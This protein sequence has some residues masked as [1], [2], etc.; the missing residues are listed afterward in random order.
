[1][2][3]PIVEQ[4]T[5]QKHQMPTT[6]PHE[7]E[8]EIVLENL[9]NVKRRIGIHSGKGGVGKTFL[10]VNIAFALANAGKQVGLLDVD[11]DCP[12]VAKFLNL[13]A[14][15]LAGHANGRIEPLDYR[16]IKIVSSHFLT[17]NPNAPMI[18]RGPIKHKV[19]A[20]F[21]SKVEWGELDVLLS[22]LPPGTADAPMSSM[23]I[24][25][26]DSVVIVTTPQKESLHDARKSALMAKD[27]DIEVLGVIENMSGEVFGSGVGKTL[28]KELNV[29]FL[30]SVP[31]MK[32][33]REL[34]ENGNIAITSLHELQEVAQN[35]VSVLLDE[36][37][38]VKQSRIKKFLRW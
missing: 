29:P 27:L 9:R 17:D 3:L 35:I 1:M 16:G 33:I 22:D 2:G 30:G 36:T 31:L 10:A 7:Q 28:A 4:Q 34:N 38:T 32:E 20:E 24:G 37:I 14:V 5:S 13:R 18:V 12:N 15:P 8:K 19:L 26:L 25:G 6:A 11:I 23:L 21:L